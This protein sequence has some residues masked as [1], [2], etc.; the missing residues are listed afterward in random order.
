M[1]KMNI[2]PFAAFIGMMTIT[3]QSSYADAEFWRQKD[4]EQMQITREQH[5][6]EM[7]KLQLKEEA[8]IRREEE[9]TEQ[10]RLKLQQEEVKRDRQRLKNKQHRYQAPPPPPARG[11]VIIINR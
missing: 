10:E 11:D 3:M 2:L 4:Q 6:Q 9:K 1:N 7:D 8:K 5:N